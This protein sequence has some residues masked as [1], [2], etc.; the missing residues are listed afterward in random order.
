MGK[1]PYISRI[2]FQSF[3][4]SCT[5]VFRV[6][7]TESR[8]EQIEG[9]KERQDTTSTFP[10]AR[11]SSRC[12]GSWPNWRSRENIMGYNLCCNKMFKLRHVLGVIGTFNYR[13]VNFVL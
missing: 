4:P 5:I 9:S 2:N 3:T 8:E 12:K 13:T 11:A 10:D 1:H 7:F 6:Q